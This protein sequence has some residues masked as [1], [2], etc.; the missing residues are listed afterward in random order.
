MPLGAAAEPF[1][2][3]K[4]LSTTCVSVDGRLVRLARVFDSTQI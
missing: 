4:W 2:E 1:I 3:D